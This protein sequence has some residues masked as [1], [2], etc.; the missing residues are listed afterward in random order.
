LGLNLTGADTVIF[1]EHDWNP[2]KDMQAM[3][4]AHRLGQKRVVNVY[5]LITRDTLEEKI[6]GLQQFKLNIANTVVNQENTVGLSGMGG[7][8][9]IDLFNTSEPET[10]KKK[11]KEKSTPGIPSSIAGISTKVLEELNSLSNNSAEEYEKE[12]DVQK[13]MQKLHSK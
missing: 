12:F 6:M 1:V 11:Q 13:F 2:Q 3:D 10:D 9:I 4:R 7:D 8:Q 5:R